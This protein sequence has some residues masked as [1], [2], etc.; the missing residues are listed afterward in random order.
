MMSV[1]RA[2]LSPR[3]YGSRQ[4]QRLHY[5][6][7]LKAQRRREALAEQLKC[8][9]CG[10]PLASEYRRGPKR[11]Y[12]PACARE[13]ANARKRTQRTPEATLAGKEKAVHQ[14]HTLLFLANRTDIVTIRQQRLKTAAEDL[15][16]Y[17][18]T[19]AKRNE[20]QRRRR[21]KAHKATADAVLQE[22]GLDAASVQE[23]AQR[24][25]EFQ[26]WAQARG[27]L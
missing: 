1:A 25:P 23:R 19:L 12:H 11:K 2:K 10:E 16:A 22:L 18:S 20:Q 24:D 15:A 6:A 3:R 27:L 21:A 14:A 13:A 17:K 8:L 26:T 5:A 7:R 9:F 4:C